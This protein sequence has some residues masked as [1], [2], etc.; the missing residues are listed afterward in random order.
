MH[1]VQTALLSCAHRQCNDADELPTAELDSIANHDISGRLPLIAMQMMVPTLWQENSF[2][3][4]ER[5]DR[6]V[7]YFASIIVQ[8]ALLESFH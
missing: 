6:P 4:A 7:E 3:Y 8:N 1:P 5:R 2:S